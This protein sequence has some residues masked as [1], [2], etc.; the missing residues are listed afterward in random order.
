M[1]GLP[2]LLM[3][4]K[5]FISYLQILIFKEIRKGDAVINDCYFYNEYHLIERSQAIVTIA[6]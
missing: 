3:N 1:G 5:S 4:L 2:D 6:A